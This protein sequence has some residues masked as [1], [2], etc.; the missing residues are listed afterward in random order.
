M[1]GGNLLFPPKSRGFWTSCWVRAKSKRG[2]H[3][4]LSSLLGRA[5]GSSVNEESPKRHLT[6]RKRREDEAEDVPCSCQQL[7]GL[8]GNGVPSLM[9]G[10]VGS[11]ARF[12]ET[13]AHWKR[14]S[15]QLHTYLGILSHSG[16]P[17][18]LS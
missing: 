4:I 2:P 5:H 18:A 3:G 16:F 11:P 8:P 12:R 13:S 1:Q 10:S 9:R 17:S 7:T 6:S 14:S 15:H